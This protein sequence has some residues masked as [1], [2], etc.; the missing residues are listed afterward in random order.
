[1]AVFLDVGFTQILIIL[2]INSLVVIETK[3]KQG[4]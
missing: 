3:F 2:L 1:M 4:N